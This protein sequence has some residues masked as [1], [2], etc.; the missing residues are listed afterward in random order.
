MKDIQTIDIIAKLEQREAELA[1]INSVQ[2]ALAANMAMQGIY[3]LVGDRIRDLFDAQVAAISIFDHENSTE[4]FKYIYEKG[5][6]F[7]PEPRQIDKIRQ[8]L[9]KTRKMILINENTGEAFTTITGE[10]PKAV[11]GTSF[12]KSMLFV[13]LTVGDNVQGYVSLQNLDREQAFSQSDVQLL[14]TLAN[15]M[16]VALENARL[17]NETEQRNAELAVINSVQEGLVAEMDMQGIY[18]LVGD[19]IRDLFDAQV[20]AIVIFDLDEKMEE[21]RYLFE[22]GD[23]LYPS[24]RSYDKVREKIITDRKTL[25]FNENAAEKLS[26]ING[27]PHKPVPGTRVAQSALYVPL[28]LGNKVQGYVTLQ[29]LD[30]EHAFSESDV[31]LLNTLANSMSVALEN[32]RLFNETEQRNA[33][34]AV[35]NSV[36]QGLVAEMDMQGIYELVGERVRDLFDAQVAAIV[37]FDLNQKTE[38]FVYLF[39]DGGRL[40]PNPRPYDKVREKIIN[41]KKTLLLNAN[42]AEQMSLINQKPFKPV[43]GT[44]TARAVLYVPMV[45]GDAVRGYVTLQNLD[46]DHAFAQ[47]DVRLLETLVNSM[48][49]ALENARLFNETARLLAITEQRNA[50]LAV[51]N[52]VQ[53]GLVREMNMQAIYELVGN[54]IC[55]VL[56]TQTLLIRTFN[57]E[58]QV[59][60]WEFAIENGE[61]LQVEPRPFIWANQYLIKEKK[62]ILINKDYIETAKKFGDKE[63]GVTKG[64]PPKSAIFVPM[65]VGD[66][67]VGSVSLQNIETENA[68]T[69]SDVRLLTTLTNSMSVAIENARLFDETKSLLKETEQRN[70]ELAVINKVQESLV[71]KM[72]IASIYELVGEKIREIFDAQVVDIV[73][74][75]KEKGLIEDRYAYE[76]G[77]RSL[78]GP[79]P[80]NGFRKQVIE[81]KQMLL[82]NE[83]VLEASIHNDNPV[84]IG[85]VAK[86][87]IFL[88]MIAAGEVKGIISLQNLDREYA[89]S[90]GDINLISTLANSMSV[91]LESARLFD[92]TTRLLKETDQ[93]NAEL[94]VINSVQ[95]SLVAKMEMQS[96]YDLVGEKI[97]ELFDAQVVDIVTYD[98]VKQVIED[99]YAYEKGDRTLLGQRMVNGF[100]KHVIET[101]QILVHNDNVAQAM[102][103]FDNEILIGDIPKS[104]VYVPMI[105]GGDV[106][107]IISLQNVDHENAFSEADVNLISTL[108]NS[109]SVALESA[110]LFDETARLLKETEQRTR[111]LSVI[112]SVQ[113]GLAKELDIQG[114]YELVG[115][116]MR[117][118]FNAQVFDIATYDKT[119]G[120]I[121]DRYTYE[122]G[123]RTLLPPR[124][125]IGF[126]K[127][128]VE[129]AKPLMINKDIK[130]HMETYGN[131]VMAG[132]FTK[133]VVFVPIIAAGEVAG[134]MSLQNVDEEDAFSDSDVRLLTTLGNSMTVA[135]ENARLFDET[136]RLLKE[137][138]QRAAEMQTVNNISRA[139]VS[140]LELDKLI[141]LVGNQMKDTFKADIVYLA[142]YDAESNMLHFPYSYGQ[143]SHSRPFANNIT[144]KIIKTRKPL[145]VN[146][147]LEKAYE[148]LKVEKKGE[149]VESFLGVPIIAGNKSI[150]V[151]SVQS[152]NTKNRFNEYDLRLLTTIA[153]NVSVA[154]Q[155]AEAYQKLQSALTNLKSAQEQLVQQEKLASL[156][157]LTAGIAHEIKNPLNFVNNFSEVSIEMIEEALEEMENKT[158]S[159]D[160]TLIR[161]ILENIKSNLLKVHEHGTR[162]NRIVTT[163]L[164]HSRGGTGKLGPTDLN[165]LIK[166][167][168]NLSFH[169]MRAGKSPINVKITL[170]LASEISEVSMIK[171]DF[172]RV[173]INLCNNAFDA[174]REKL[175]RNEGETESAV[176]YLPEL[177]VRTGFENGKVLISFQDNGPGIPDEIKDKILQPFFTTKKGTEGTGLGLSITHDIVKAHGGEIDVRSKVEEGTTFNIYLP[178]QQ[179]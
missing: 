13:P 69:E 137:T 58:K 57:H 68:F 179:I 24:K 166:E 4:N 104:Q 21:F 38:H 1:V 15:T 26:G 107:G 150:G 27:E 176:N 14:N 52:S 130:K 8:R 178:I 36:Q 98:P 139:L 169:G 106:K 87:A 152:K 75:D 25:L 168:V 74:Y 160:D 159:K 49:V 45:V 147:D 173:V 30:R 66:V 78:L 46:R 148:Q 17:F 11:P 89:F 95:E 145:L 120:L 39:E 123:D 127:W 37:T 47:S 48:S 80:V 71:A 43:P 67:V 70:S 161:E 56:N 60:K 122:K 84:E 85:E 163:M 5:E 83:N 18:D 153:A 31:R 105:A 101:K 102:L 28:L 142:L 165:A 125:L 35:I 111:E 164:Q 132:E 40:Y 55:E 138:E 124:E 22:D 64:L 116:K 63:K 172:T 128:V 99:R 143:K 34:L 109:M 134:V 117:E 113:D 171:E 151:I 94:A 96:I 12:P 115:E 62:S 103:D 155:N 65:V 93:R 121:E 133:S 10:A 112:T 20:T 44:Q 100:R 79:R 118:I 108:A 76:K 92:E 170:G 33:E 146:Q 19:R 91:A 141:D 175:K 110:R 9:I 2:E 59:E 77:D 16:S 162:A 3:D 167:Y 50:E 7:Y 126:R 29:N 129:N 119:T 136:N 53:D 135:L 72:D 114:I 88:P 149:W 32:A 131:V 177:T 86:S 82:L 154:M 73:T 23:R 54:R 158:D 81:S 97:R 156:G 140:Q 42:A 61:R 90:E 6:R 174:M 51:I 41:E 157:Q 144:E